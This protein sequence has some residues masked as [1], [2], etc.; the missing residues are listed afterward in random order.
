MPEGIRGVFKLILSGLC[1]GSSDLI[2]GV[3]GGT[4]CFILGI[5]TD[6]IESIRTFNL[7]ALA[8]LAKGRFWLFQKAVAWE[9]ILSLG[10]GVRCSIYFPKP[11][12]S[13]FF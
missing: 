7:H 1:M 6:L 10:T 13:I 12:D 11:T 3:S 8:L 5:Y 2:P 4:I 9:F